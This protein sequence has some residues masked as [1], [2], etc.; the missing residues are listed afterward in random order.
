MQAI[1]KI[2][3]E[4][5]TQKEKIKWKIINSFKSKQFWNNI[6][7]KKIYS[8]LDFSIQKETHFYSFEMKKKQF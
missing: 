5:H 3:R 8:K 2:E 1:K 6:R 4:R 7:E